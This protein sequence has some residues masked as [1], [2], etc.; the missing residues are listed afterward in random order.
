MALTSELLTAMENMDDILSNVD[1]SGTAGSNQ[2]RAVETLNHAQDFL[3]TVIGAVEDLLPSVDDSVSQT[4]GQEY[5]S[6][7]SRLLRIDSLW[8]LDASD[9][10]PRYEIT[11]I[12]N[13][14][15][16]R[17]GSSSP[18]FS[19]SSSSTGRP[20]GYWWARGAS[21]VYW[22]RQ[23]DATNNVRFVGFFGAA[24]ITI[25]PDSTFAYEDA[26]IY[27]VAQVAATVFRFRRR[28]NWEEMRA[29]A[30]SVFEPVV[31]QMQRAWRHQRGEIRGSYPGW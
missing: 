30:M 17:T 6:T 3:E 23:P 10:L 22:S 29:Y 15:G 1:I 24:D 20:E 12:R 14:G 26:L 21:R 13:P 7:P 27:P 25:A 31:V 8:F 16:H 4:V 11:P 9:S 18:L 19:V 5:S 28:D 2:T